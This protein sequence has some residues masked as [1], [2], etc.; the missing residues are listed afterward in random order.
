MNLVKCGNA[1][2]IVLF[3][4]AKF[5]NWKAQNSITWDFHLYVP[6]WNENKV[7]QDNQSFE[8]KYKKVEG[9]ILC[10]IKRHEPYLDIDYD[11]LESFNFF[12]SDEE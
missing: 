4:F 10:N 6:W 3:V 11:G 5:P 2:N 7:K 1:V 12:Q 9:N 8:G